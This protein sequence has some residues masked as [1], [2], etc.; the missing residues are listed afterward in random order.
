[1]VDL[2]ELLVLVVIFSFFDIV[3]LLVLVGISSH[4]LGAFGIIYIN[5]SDKKSAN[6]QLKNK[7]VE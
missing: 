7:K 2:L 1:M 3:F 4:V 5:D 6:K